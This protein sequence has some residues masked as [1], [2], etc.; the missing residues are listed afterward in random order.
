L[1]TA[2]IYLAGALLMV[3]FTL[4]TSLVQSYVTDAMRGRVM[5]VYNVAFRG[6]MP[7]GSVICGYLIEKS[8]VPI[9]MAGNGVLIVILALYFLFVQKKLAKL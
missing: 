5:S 8:S 3:V 9:V 4:N 2:S 6:G 7:I 1:T